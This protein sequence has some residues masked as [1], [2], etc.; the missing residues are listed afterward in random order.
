MQK[1]ELT[2]K[3]SPTNA[4]Q[5]C[6]SE[7]S[8]LNMEKTSYSKLKP[9]VQNIVR[10]SNN[11]EV[12]QDQ[13]TDRSLKAKV[14]VLNLQGNPLMP[15]SY[16]KSKRMVK[17]GKAKVVKKFPFTIQL[18]FECEN[19]VQDINLGIDSGYS[20]IG[21]SAI[22]KKEELISGELKLEN[23][24][25]K[26]LE[27]KRMYRR[28]RRNKLW[29]RKSRWQNRT[30]NKKENWLPPSI[31]RRYQTHINLIN[32]IKKLLPITKIIIEVGK[33]DIQKIEN[34]EIQGKAYQQGDMF[35]YRNRIA[36]LIVREKG[37]CQYCNKEY[38]K[39]N[40]WRLHHIWGKQK[41][42]PEDWV[43]IHEKCH[44]ELHLK[45]EE[46]ILKKQKSKSYK[47]S[48]FM[49]IIRKKFWNDICNLEVTY[50]NY[51]FQKRI[52]LGINKTHYNDAFIISGGIY[53]NRCKP[54]D[55][56]QK[57]KNNRCLQMNRK[58]FKPSIRKQRYNIQ[59]KDLV[60]INNK[61]FETS[62]CH[63]KGTRLLINKISVPI[64]KVQKIFHTKT[65]IW[66]TLLFSHN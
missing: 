60:K 3:N 51:T 24:M 47:N 1:L 9:S 34:P 35:E 64:K 8:E 2:L 31:E 10:D 18:N 55:I 44:K 33:F 40:P 57:R 46:Y 14:F 13:Q 11:G 48:V 28:N 37:I 49:N 63:C 59:P 65:L 29:Y 39:N 22:T 43:L 62:G 25:V 5:V 20:F 36:Y 58:G 66:R 50:G 16:A 23:G 17:T 27:E 41:D 32:Q 53:Q 6:S 52:E 45:K 19:K 15:C 12:N 61:W 42:R 26:R 56:I 7:N 21:F 38:Q 30:N 54:I 4:S